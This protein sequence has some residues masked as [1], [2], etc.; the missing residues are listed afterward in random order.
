M[1]P[2]LAGRSGLFQSALEL[3]VGLLVHL[4]LGIHLDR[5]VRLDALAV[6]YRSLGVR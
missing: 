3:R 4:L 1:S 6:D 5:D 2:P